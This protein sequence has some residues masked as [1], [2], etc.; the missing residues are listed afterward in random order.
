[1]LDAEL[2][3]IARRLREEPGDPETWA[4]ALD[5]YGRAGRLEEGVALLDRIL[6]TRDLGPSLAAARNRVLVRA[7]WG[8]GPPGP[9]PAERGPW[10]SP[11]AE[12]EDG[13]L[14]WVSS[15]GLVGIASLP[16]LADPVTWPLPRPGVA[17][18]SAPEDAPEYPFEAL[19]ARSPARAGWVRLILDS[20]VG[21]RPGPLV[22]LDLEPDAG[23]FVRVG[24]PGF[25]V[26]GRPYGLDHPI[27]DPAG[28]WLLLAA[29]GDQGIHDGA[30]I[31]DTSLDG[32]VRDLPLPGYPHLEGASFGPAGRRLAIPCRGVVRV[33]HLDEPGVAWDYEGPAG[34]ELVTALAGDGTL[35]L[36]TADFPEGGGGEIRIYPECAR[37]ASH[38]RV[39]E[40]PTGAGIPI[41]R[42]AWDGPGLVAWVQGQ[43]LLRW[44]PGR[45]KPVAV[46]AAAPAYWSGVR[47]GRYLRWPETMTRAAPPDR[48]APPLALELA[49]ACQG[50][51]FF[52]RSRIVELRAL[53]GGALLTRGADGTLRYLD[54][55]TGEVRVLHVDHRLSAVDSAAQF[56][57]VVGPGCY[58]V[59]DLVERAPRFT[60]DLPAA[61]PF[62][63]VLAYDDARD[64]LL[65]SR[66]HALEVVEVSSGRIL[67]EL[68]GEP[69]LLITG[70]LLGEGAQGWGAYQVDDRQVV[71]VFDLERGTR[72]ETWALREPHVLERQMAGFLS[73]IER[74]VAP[75]SLALAEEPGGDALWLGLAQRLFRLAP[76]RPPELV[77]DDAPLPLFAPL[78]GGRRYVKW[79]ERGVLGVCERDRGV[80]ER[81]EVGTRI[82][83]VAL[84]ADGRTLAYTRG[85]RVCFRD[86][87]Q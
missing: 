5:A 6:A 21:P 86:V 39:F 69:G 82:E 73:E 66:F 68:P 59:W 15:D 67:R 49:T 29:A 40:A 32:T 27:I 14:A 9:L 87:G 51:D 34:R 60:R 53:P 17:G 84:L 75:G 63:P 10:G 56:G 79:V 18:V 28:R 78:P 20:A 47:G 77:D 37:R 35:A 76:G 25:S 4:A 41:S 62:I 8:M 24:D 55:A 13:R 36:A 23:E 11:P 12:L 46:T 72:V 64:R 71:A 57:V 85:D 30:A 19:V 52:P 74:G 16:G 45:G 2:E 61:W 80:L 44:V 54:P 83:D 1:M 26:E 42:L 31:L 70:G 58:T 81:L 7:G 3:D 65:R 22:V 33:F 38:R 43:M 48:A 50:E